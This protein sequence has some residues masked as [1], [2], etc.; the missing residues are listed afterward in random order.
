MTR[1]NASLDDSSSLRF[2]TKPDHQHHPAL[3]ST[4]KLTLGPGAQVTRL[5]PQHLARK[6]GYSADAQAQTPPQPLDHAFLGHAMPDPHAQDPVDMLDQG[7]VVALNHVLLK[8]LA[9]VQRDL[10]GILQQPGVCEAELALERGCA[11]ARRI[12]HTRLTFVRCVLP[13]GRGDGAHYRQRSSREKSTT[14]YEAARWPV[15]AQ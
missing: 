7:K 11:S 14:A 15:R 6:D 4:C 9:V 10:L 8:L 2:V 5:H 13:K 3:G 1:P 12:E